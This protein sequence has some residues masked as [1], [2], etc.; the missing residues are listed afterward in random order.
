MAMVAINLYHFIPMKKNIITHI[1]LFIAFNSIAIHRSFCQDTMVLN[2][3]TKIG[4]KVLTVKSKSVDY[5]MWNSEDESVFNIKKSLLYYIKYNN[6]S[7]D[8]INH[9]VF[10]P[11]PIEIKDTALPVIDSFNTT[12]DSITGNYVTYDKGFQDGFNTYTNKSAME[13]CGVTTGIVGIIGIVGPIIYMTEKVKPNKINNA[14]YT[15][16]KDSQ[17]KKGFINGASKRRQNY[18]W[19]GFGIGQGARILIGVALI[20]AFISAF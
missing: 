5:V 10:A 6:G 8:T 19:T 13:I 3:L 17:Y 11:D 20:I 4:C 15:D 16:S 14:L 1:L 2:D 18:A 12:I 7:I 9:I